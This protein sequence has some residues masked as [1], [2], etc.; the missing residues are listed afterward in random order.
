MARLDADDC[1]ASD[2]N[3]AIKFLS[4][5]GIEAEATPTNPMGKLLASLPTFDDE[6]EAHTT[7]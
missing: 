7:Q 4:A 3:A 1:N 2:I 6:D 5:N